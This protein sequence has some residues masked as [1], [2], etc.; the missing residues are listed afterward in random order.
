MK[1]FLPFHIPKLVKS[2]PFYI[3][4][5]PE[6]GTPFGQSLRIG[7]YREYPPPG[8]GRGLKEQEIDSVFD[9]WLGTYHLLFA[10]GGKK[11]RGF[12]S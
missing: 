2:L 12:E 11:L 5:K 1:I 8:G 3:R 9:F 10:I 7:H 6:K 4:L